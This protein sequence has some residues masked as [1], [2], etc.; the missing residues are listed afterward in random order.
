MHSQREDL[1]V[2]LVR[3]GAFEREEVDNLHQVDSG[4]YFPYVS[5]TWNENKRMDYILDSIN[6]YQNLDFSPYDDAIICLR[7]SSE[8][9]VSEAEKEMLL[10]GLP[11]SLKSL[12]VK[13]GVGIKESLKE[14]VELM[15]FLNK[16]K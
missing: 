11:A 9:P 7:S 8:H 13:V 2:K 4:Q 14:E 5:R 3:C 16:M 1:I 6:K 12:P 10:A 15:L